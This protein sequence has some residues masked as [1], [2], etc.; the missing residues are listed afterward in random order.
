[1]TPKRFK[2]LE[3]T[4]IWRKRIVLG[5]LLCAFFVICARVF[6]LQII[7]ADRLRELAQS[8]YEGTIEI[9][10]KRGD[11]LDAKGNKLAAS[12]KV[13]SLYAD[14]KHIK[15]KNQIAGSLARILAMNQ[16]EIQEKLN[17]NRSFVWIKRKLTPEEEKR[18]L[19]LNCS[20]LRLLPEPKRVYPHFNLA[21]HILGF[22]NID[23]KGLEGLELKYDKYLRGRKL[24]H[25]I[26]RDARKRIIDQEDEGRSS[27]S[28]EGS[29]LVLTL[30]KYI[31]YTVEKEL[32]TVRKE[33]EAKAALAIVAEPNTGKILAMAVEPSFNPNIFS[34]YPQQTL[35]NRTVTDCFEPG[36]TMK[37][38]TASLVLKNRCGRP[39]DIYF[40]ENGTYKLGK[41]IIHDVHKHGWLSLR[42]IIQVSSNIGALKMGQ[43]L[44]AAD[45]YDGLR[46]F[47]F[48][49]RSGIDVPGEVQ[50][51]LKKGESWTSVDK[52]VISFGQGISV[53]PIQLI[54]GFCAIANGGR[55]M[56]PYIVERIFDPNGNEVFR[57]EPTQEKQ[58]LSPETA[59]QMRSILQLVVREGGSGTAANIEGYNVAGKT[60]TAQ[61]VVPGRRGYSRSKYVSSFAGFFPADRPQIAILVMV[62]EPHRQTYGGL[63]AAP[64]FK[65]IAEKIIPYLGIEP[66]EVLIAQ[67]QIEQAALEAQQRKT[68]SIKAEQL[69]EIVTVD[70]EGDGMP[71]LI[72]LDM[73]SALTVLD[74]IDME[75]KVNGSGYVIRQE[76]VP[77]QSINGI[78]KCSLW[79]SQEKGLQS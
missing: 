43:K 46:Q 70:D 21:S 49:E 24:T 68:A 32:R 11:I 33:Q 35:R 37:V 76:P 57:N 36:S 75:V 12:V 23:G 9:L 58:T 22:V 2:K 34:E 8:E 45:F 5:I 71:N 27:G 20:E 65:A 78:T 15:N 53:S 56:R 67:K 26:V 25:R 61:K 74:D 28:L 17:M 52:A 13:H 14:A 41:H 3:N 7:E 42:K 60:G 44:P 16:Y 73:R 10:P 62:D 63:V 79:L 55:L 66:S 48:G 30:D 19:N 1:M 4:L 31:Q 64:V 40:C 54:M 29:S 38:F 39:S 47:G 72:G 51:I 59:E 18:I 77:G 69:A 50:G 6:Y